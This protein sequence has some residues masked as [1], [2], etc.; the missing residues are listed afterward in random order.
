M[1]KGIHLSKKSINVVMTDGTMMNTQTVATLPKNL[2][3]L[4][5]DNKKHPC[6]NP[7][8][9]TRSFDVGNRLQKFKN[10]YV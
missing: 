9:D 5:V 10:K 7:H 2:L 1:K 8:V 6:W 3:K 4:D